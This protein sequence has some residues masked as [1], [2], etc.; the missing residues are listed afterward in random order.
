[1]VGRGMPLR[2]GAGTRITFGWALK[3]T[4]PGEWLVSYH[5]TARSSAG[6]IM[7][8]AMTST[9]EDVLNVVQ[10]LLHSYKGCRTICT[11]VYG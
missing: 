4:E 9:R 10:E 11:P 8:L 2:S 6:N 5:G 1:M 3:V 7:R